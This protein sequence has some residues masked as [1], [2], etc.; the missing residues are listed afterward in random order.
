MWCLPTPTPQESGAT[1]LI[2][3]NL[4]V[5]FYSFADVRE[6]ESIN[7]HRAQRERSDPRWCSNSASV[8][9]QQCGEMASP[10]A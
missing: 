3:V 1:Q 6:S 10:Y 7:R 9:F 8:G 5:C 4:G 2:G